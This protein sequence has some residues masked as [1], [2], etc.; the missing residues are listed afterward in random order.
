MTV[1][2]LEPGDEALLMRLAEED[3]EF[4]LEENAGPGVPLSEDDALAYLADPAVLH[5]VAERDGRVLGHL[6]CHVLRRRQGAARHLLLYD[7]GVRASERRRGVGRSLIAALRDWMTHHGV[8]EVWV[9]VDPAAEAF[10]RAC[11]FVLDR[12]QPIQMVLELPPRGG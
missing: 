4:G 11:G 2:L 9:E 6:L 7:I 10:Y 8:G 3:E 5:W 1:R 12:E